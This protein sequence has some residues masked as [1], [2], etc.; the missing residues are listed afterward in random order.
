MGESAQVC[1][2]HVGKHM[3]VLDSSLIFVAVRILTGIQIL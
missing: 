1:M 2:C 3:R